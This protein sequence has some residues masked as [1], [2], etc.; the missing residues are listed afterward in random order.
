MAEIRRN[1]KNIQQSGFVLVGVNV[2]RAV[3]RGERL[4]SEHRLLLYDTRNV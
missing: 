3:Q 1:V 4:V 2:N